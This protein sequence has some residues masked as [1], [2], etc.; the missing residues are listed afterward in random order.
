MS[1]QANARRLGLTTLALAFSGST[2]L[3][4]N[5]VLVRVLPPS[6]YGGVARTFSLGMAVAQLTMAGVA[7]A[8]AREVAGGQD[9]DLRLSRARGAIRALGCCCGAVSLLYFPLA[10]AGLAPADVLSLLLGWALALVYSLYFGLKLLL[11]VLNWSA[12]YAAL[13]MASDAIFFVALVVLALIVPTAGV[14]AFSVAYLFF[15]G[16][17]MRLI[18]RRQTR[19]ERLRVDR[20]V[21]VYTGWASVATYASIGRF[22]VAVTLT[23]A[24]VGSAGAGRLAALLAI[25]MPFFLLPQA[26]AVLTFAD[27]A[28]ARGGGGDAGEPVR[29]MCRVSAWVSAL[30][31]CICCLF[32]PEVVQLA[33]GSSYRSQTASFLILMLCVAPQVTALPAGQALAA[34]GAVRANAA[35]A[36]AGFL[37]MAIGIALLVPA[38]GVL[39]GAIA[40]G[41]S[42]LVTGVSVLSLGHRRFEIGLREVA[43]TATAIG[44]GLVAVTLSQAQLA[45]RGGVLALMLLG[46]AV[47]FT[48][49][50]W[51]PSPRTEYT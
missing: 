3:L 28:R 5:L 8:V 33:L 6:S 51:R 32:G 35:C 42:M 10:L 23:G 9:D 15:I 46:A 13:E 30:V 34:Q 22:A 20:R 1:D 17:A 44:L 31:I 50:R 24:I 47:S 36:L 39:G 14:L 38:Y 41:A 7:P 18:G 37:V 4:F 45:E 49:T 21:L 43:G 26:A 48:W 2:T 11:F 16:A 19:T 27:M 29:L 12:R 25:V 40:F